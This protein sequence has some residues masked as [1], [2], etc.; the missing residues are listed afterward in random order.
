MCGRLNQVTRV[1]HLLRVG[2]LGRARRRA[3]DE[4]EDRRVGRVF[5]YNI[6]PTDYAD[7]LLVDGGELVM[8][9]MRFGLIPAWARG[10]KREVERKFGFTFN[11][12]CESVFELAS[13]R[14]AI[15]QRRCL[16]PVS[17]WHEWP[18]RACPYY[19]Q[20]RDQG[21]LLLAGIWERWQ[22][23]LAEDEEEG[24]VITSMS[25]VTTPPGATL[26]RF[27]DRSPLVL[28]PD[29]AEAWLLAGRG[30]GEVEPFL[31]PYDSEMLEGYRVSLAVNSARNKTAEVV[32]PLRE[33]F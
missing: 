9:R 3:A 7:V 21:G 25:V 13:F 10:G 17:G 31:K 19:I 26:A 2:S 1:P 22:S 16:V 28:E 14:A 11:A 4:R 30:R 32:E 12:R 33:L 27:H 24:A 6:C 15:L 5:E 23:G 8:E 20:R 29:A 18:D